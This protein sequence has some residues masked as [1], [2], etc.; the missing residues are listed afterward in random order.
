MNFPCT[1]NMRPS[2]S[3]HVF[4]GISF[5]PWPCAVQTVSIELAIF[6][7][8]GAEKCFKFDIGLKNIQIHGQI[9]LRLS[10]GFRDSPLSAWTRQ[11]HWSSKLFGQMGVHYHSLGHSLSTRVF[12]TKSA[13][14]WTS[15][16]CLPYS[17]E[18]VS[19]SRTDSFGGQIRAAR[20]TYLTYSTTVSLS[21]FASSTKPRVAKH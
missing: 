6:L 15:V 13:S 19:E 16:N 17:S 10:P 3:L 14:A 12:A 8:Y 20:S 2:I 21:T 4:S 7:C 9:S 1:A 5:K 11:G 18:L